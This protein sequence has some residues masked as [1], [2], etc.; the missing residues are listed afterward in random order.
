VVDLEE[1]VQPEAVENHDSSDKAGSEKPEAG[2]K[3]P[4]RKLSHWILLFVAALAVAGATSWWLGSQNYESTDDA[5]I[6][7]HLD[8][9]S[10]RISGTVTYI[11]PRVENNQLVEAGTLLME[12][13]PRDYAAELEHAKA[14]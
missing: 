10:A 4:R 5:Q 3:A 9:V 8:S 11:N 6:E 2:T 1:T 7:G 12:L 14:N 13:D